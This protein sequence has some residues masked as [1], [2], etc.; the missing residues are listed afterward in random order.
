MPTHDTQSIIASI[1]TDIYS[2]LQQFAID[3]NFVTAVTACPKVADCIR[4][5]TRI[6]TIAETS[7]EIG[8]VIK[9]FFKPRKGKGDG[10][11]STIM[12][13][14]NIVLEIHRD[15]KMKV[16]RK[17]LGCTTLEGLELI[18]SVV[19][20]TYRKNGMQDDNIIDFCEETK[21][22]FQLFLQEYAV[23]KGHLSIEDK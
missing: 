11:A 13:M 21:R 7:E 6:F 5:I 3:N 18:F 12:E 1:P 23:S 2:E 4:E 10:V 22:E 20:G 14:I 19:L 9:L 17:V 16:A 8:L 15:P